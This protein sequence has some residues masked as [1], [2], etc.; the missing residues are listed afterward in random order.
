MSAELIIREKVMPE[1]RLGKITSKRQLTIP[2][3]FF[4]KLGLSG[5]VEIIL[6]NDELRIRRYQR[7][8]ESHDY[9]ADLILK[10][11]L[12][13]GIE[14][15]EEILKEFRLRMDLLPLAVQDYVKDVRNKTAYDNRTPEELDKALFGE[16]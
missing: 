4:D 16:E 7:L 6:D 1:T 13:E 10:S 12:D 3:D 11:I 15:K 9:F 2:K 14:G 5:D 8:E